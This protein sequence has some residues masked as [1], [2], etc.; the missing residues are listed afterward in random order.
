MRGYRVAPP[1]LA[2][3]VAAYEA[4]LNDLAGWDQGETYTGHTDERDHDSPGP[5]TVAREVLT[6]MGA[7][8]TGKVMR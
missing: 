1:K 2:D 4:V 3:K 6:R 7:K 8:R 5:A